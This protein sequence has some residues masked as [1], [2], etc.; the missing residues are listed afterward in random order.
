MDSER[1]IVL[2]VGAHAIVDDLESVR[3]G[4]ALRWAVLRSIAA[5]DG[6][7]PWPMAHTP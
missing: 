3:D 2:P 4:S 6:H 5:S 7:G 1:I